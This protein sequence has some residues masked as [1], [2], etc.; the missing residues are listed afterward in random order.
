MNSIHENYIE[1]IVIRY[2]VLILLLDNK[3]NNSYIIIS[4]TTYSCLIQSKK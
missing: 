2:I 1:H 4:I 3:F